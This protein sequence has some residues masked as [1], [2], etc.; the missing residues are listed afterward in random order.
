MDEIRLLQQPP[1]KDEANAKTLSLLNTRIPNWNALMHLEGL[2]DWVRAAEEETNSLNNELATSTSNLSKEKAAVVDAT[3]TTVT[4]AQDAALARHILSDDLSALSE[5]L[6]SSR[7]HGLGQPTLL[8]DLEAL[9]RNLKGLQHVQQYVRVI[10]Q[11]LSLSAAAIDQFKAS[12]KQKEVTAASLS[13]YVELQDFTKKVA[14][15]CKESISTPGSGSESLGLVGF[16]NSVRNHT[17]SSLK[18]LLFEELIACAEKLKW[19]GAV[20]WLSTPVEDRQLFVAAFLKLLSLQE[21]GDSFPIEPGDDSDVKSGVYP[22]QAL[23]QPV[24]ARFKYHFDGQR[25]TNRIDKPEW[26]FTHILNIIHQ[27][28]GF[29]ETTIQTVLNSTKYKTINAQR[30]FTRTL[31]PIL[32]K[33]LKRSMPDLLQNSALLAHTIYQAIVFDTQVKEDG[34]AL[35]GTLQP[36]G[37]ESGDWEGVSDVILGRKEWF[38]A[39]LEG[40][41]LFAEAQYDEVVHSPDAWQ[42][43]DDGALSGEDAT[44]TTD[45]RPT[46]SA[47]RIKALFEQIADRY[48]P[49]PKFNHRAQFL[50]EIQVSILEHYHTRISGSLDAFE[51]LTSSLMRAVPGAL[52]GQVG[53]QYDTRRLTSGVDGLQRLIKAFVSARWITIAMQ[54]WGEQLFYLE[55]WKEINDRAS[56]R[57]KAR[58]HMSLP[59]PTPDSVVEGT[60]FDELIAQYDTLTARSEDLIVQHVVSETDSALRPH[61]ASPWTTA[62][63]EGSVLPSTLLVP[64][65]ALQQQLAF[66]STILPATSVTILYRRICSSISSFLVERM[67]L[68]HSRSK[69]AV[70]DSAVLTAEYSL[71]IECSRQAVGKLVRKIDPPWQRLKEAATVLNME[72]D[73]YLELVRAA[74]DGNETAFEQTCEKFGISS[75]TQREMRQ[76]LRLRSDCPR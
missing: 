61:V 32:A 5:E 69:L 23:A 10:Q 28:R 2:E 75:F 11:A 16:L 68:Q 19:P 52:A 64:V 20:D 44:A 39:W 41:R 18:T 12:Q 4:A 8:E 60:L 54:N 1:S 50:I 48:K 72:Q 22:L 51:T 13:K 43:I 67:V 42:L 14:V 33:K 66:I 3:T 25:E 70:T 40:E 57:E 46:N 17:W 29:M 59:N 49:L 56:L 34:F 74:W 7:E 53:H 65:T 38:D 58:G 30:E 55:L 31:F 35:T 71:W 9:H 15:L 26:Y 37:S 6:V 63:E 27:H 73:N 62:S 76:A 36:S 45:L 21:I 47:R 24:S